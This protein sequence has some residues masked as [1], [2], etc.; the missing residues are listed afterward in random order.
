[1]SKFLITGVSS[2]IGRVLTKRLIGEGHI[3]W[4]IARGEDLLID[5]KRELKNSKLF[6]YS[7]FDVSGDGVW[8]IFVSQMKKA[9]FIPDVVIFDA[10]ILKN[11]LADGLDVGLTKKIL[12]VNFLSILYA[13]RELLPIFRERTQFIAISSSSAF[14]GSGVEGVGYPS[15]KAALSIAFESLHQKYGCNYSF[16]VVFF[17][18]VRTGMT[19]FKRR[20]PLSLSVEDAVSSILKSIQGTRVLYFYPALLFFFVKAIRLLPSDL[21]FKIL[22]RLES[23]HAKMERL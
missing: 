19:P 5:L 16:K 14:K 15:S 8:G 11:D 21:Y 10:A 17:G 9:D 12:D 4:G 7:H 20:F 3:V 2:G 22:S 23:F 1:M 6:I 18:P 13:I